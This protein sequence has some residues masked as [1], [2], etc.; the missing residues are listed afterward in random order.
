MCGLAL[1]LLLL[2]LFPV[3]GLSSPGESRST[4][5]AAEATPA[6]PRAAA[7]HIVARTIERERERAIRSGS[8]YITLDQLEVAGSITN[9]VKNAGT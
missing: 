4:S 6:N 5:S 9:D 8:G 1:P 3:Y 2:L 7:A